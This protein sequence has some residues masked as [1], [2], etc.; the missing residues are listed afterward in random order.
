MC[1][2]V[3]LCVCVSV[4]VCVC[5]SVRVCVIFCT[6]LYIHRIS[7]YDS[8]IALVSSRIHSYRTLP[9]IVLHPSDIISHEWSDVRNGAIRVS[10][11]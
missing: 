11:T 4:C 1:V 10:R 8:C 7:W 6:L 2:C 5:V 3:C 9:Y